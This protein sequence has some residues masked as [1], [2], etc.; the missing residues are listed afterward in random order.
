[1]VDSSRVGRTALYRKFK[2]YVGISIANEI[3]RLR[4]EKAMRLLESTET[5]ISNI[6]IH[7]GYGSS[8]Q[9]R[10]SFKRIM[11]MTPGGSIR[12]IITAGYLTTTLYSRIM[13]RLF[14]KFQVQ[15]IIGSPLGWSRTLAPLDLNKRSQTHIILILRFNSE[16]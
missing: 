11:K 13:S 1:M 10:R 6:T 3:D 9:L 7:C 8:H 15:D 12:Q 16:E 14:L 5:N 4:V 2:R